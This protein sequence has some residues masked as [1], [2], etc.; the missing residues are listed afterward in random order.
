MSLDF[1]EEQ[2]PLL[3]AELETFSN[4]VSKQIGFLATEAESVLSQLDEELQLELE[5]TLVEIED[6]AGVISKVRCSEM[7]EQLL[8]KLA[9]IRSYLHE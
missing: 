2:L 4:H 7:S 3:I 9:Q 1:V 8:Q 5:R 6:L